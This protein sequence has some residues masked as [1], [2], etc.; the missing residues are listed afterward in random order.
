MEPPDM[1][2]HPVGVD[3]CAARVFRGWNPRLRDETPLGFV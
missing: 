2:S 1:G 3:I